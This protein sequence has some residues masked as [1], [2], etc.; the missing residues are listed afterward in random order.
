MDKVSVSADALRQVLTALMGP[1]HYIAELKVCMS[2]PGENAI[3]TLVNEYNQAVE[4]LN[5]TAGNGEGA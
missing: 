5:E 1:P 2:L 4:A 3:T